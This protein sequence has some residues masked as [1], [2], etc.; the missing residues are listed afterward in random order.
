MDLNS[1][2]VRNFRLSLITENRM[3]INLIKT[4]KSKELKTGDRNLIEY[5][6]KYLIYNKYNKLKCVCACNI[7]DLAQFIFTCYIISTRTSITTIS[8]IIHEINS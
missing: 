4:S 5:K 7:V 3:I 6:T 8:I 1:S 2:E